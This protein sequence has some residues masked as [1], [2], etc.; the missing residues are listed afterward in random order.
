MVLK[1]AIEVGSGSLLAMASK[2]PALAK[3]SSVGDEEK[4]KSVVKNWKGMVSS[5]EI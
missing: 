3:K 1:R 2:E 5:K 4:K